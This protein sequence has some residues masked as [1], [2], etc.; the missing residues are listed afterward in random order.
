MPFDVPGLTDVRSLNRDNL[1]AFLDGA[2]ATVPNS[3]LRVLSDMNAGGAYLN[4]LYLAYIA[5]NALPDTADDEWLARWAYILFGGPKAATFAAGT[6]TV[7]GA[8]GAVLPG[9]SIFAT[10][11]GVQYQVGSADTILSAASTPVAVTCL[12]AGAIGNR[13]AGTPMALTVAANVNAQAAVILIDGGANAESNDD[14]RTRVLLRLRRPPQGGDADDYVEWALSVPGVT[15]AWATPNGMGIGT[16][17]VRV[18]FDDIRAS[19]DGLPNAADLGLV[20]AYLDTVRPV[21]VKD[22]AVVAPIPQGVAITIRNLSDDTPAMRL[23]IAGAVRQLLTERAAPG[24]TIFASWVSAAISEVVGGGSFDLD[25]A[26]A[27]MSSPGNIAS[28]N[29]AAGGGITYP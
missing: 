10:T 1:A 24:Q 19:N 13:D 29:A 14:L 5:K 28:L 21:C 7:T 22:F 17:I 3:A 26:D 6:I 27:V 16:V 4:L 9:G 18:M 11:D 2:D 15:R 8:I 12:T 23:A 20:S 25:F